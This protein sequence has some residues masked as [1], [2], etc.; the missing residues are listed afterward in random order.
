M[1]TTID[2]TFDGNVFR[3]TVPVELEPNTSVRLIVERIGE[4]TAIDSNG[5]APAETPKSFLRTAMSAKINGPPDWATNF[6]EY[7]SGERR[8]SD[9]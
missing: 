3:P 2:A 1:S 9:E 8:H 7:L 6:R 5:S 4:P